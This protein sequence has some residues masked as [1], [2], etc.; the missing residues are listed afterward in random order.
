MLVK[1][2]LIE[3]GDGKLR[4]SGGRSCYVHRI[5]D[6]G[7]YQYQ[8]FGLALVDVSRPEQLAENGYI[9]D[10]RNFIQLSLRS[11]IQEP[12][13]SER[14]AILQFDIRFC[15][16]RR[17]GWD[18]EPLYCQSIGEI[19]RAH[20]RGDMKPNRPIIRDVAGE[21]Q[22]HTEGLELNRHSRKAIS[23]LNQWKRKLPS[24]KE[25]GLLPVQCHQ[26]RLGQN[27]EHTL[28]L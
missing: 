3:K 15:P 6:V 12:G 18:C 5:D 27:L 8:Q 21:I 13:D 10:P 2:R 20:L 16:T 28:L 11:I 14:L 23:W 17:D 4:T 25:C 9:A 26:V 24:C 7:C 1:L 22:F 19:Q